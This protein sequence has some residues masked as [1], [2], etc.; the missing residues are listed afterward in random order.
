MNNLYRL[1]GLLLFFFFPVFHLYAGG[2]R[3]ADSPFARMRR[4][5]QLFREKRYDD[6]IAELVLLVDKYPEQIQKAQM[7]VLKIEKIKSQ[8][9]E[10]FLELEEAMLRDKIDVSNNIISEIRALDPYTEITLSN[11]IIASLTIRKEINDRHRNQVFDKA[12]QELAEGQYA[13]SVNTYIDGFYSED[14][15]EFFD[16]YV[17]LARNGQEITRYRDD[18]ERQQRVLSVYRDIAPEGNK[19]IQ[20]LQILVANWILKVG[21]SRRNFPVILQ[22]ISAQPPD[23]WPS[24]LAVPLVELDKT[25]EFL[26]NVLIY[27]EL[28]EE[29]WNQMYERLNQFPEDFRFQRVIQLLK[30]R[31]DNEGKEG[32]IPAIL[33]YWENYSHKIANLMDEIIRSRIVSAMDS[34]NNRLWTDARN[35][36]QIVLAVAQAL[37]DFS[38]S[39]GEAPPGAEKGDS[40]VLAESTNSYIG[41]TVRAW[42][43][44]IDIQSSVSGSIDV[45]SRTLV[46]LD[47]VNQYGDSIQVGLNRAEELL[48][49]WDISLKS[50]SSLYPVTTDTVSFALD[51]LRADILE[52]IRRYREQRSNLYLT[53]MK[54]GYEILRG[55]QTKVFSEEKIREIALLV[56]VEGVT[57]QDTTVPERHPSLAIEQEIT[58]ILSRLG[59][60]EANINTYIDNIDLILD[61]NPPVENSETIGQLREDARKLLQGLS[62]EK[63]RLNDIRVEALEFANRS[64]RFIVTATTILNEVD[65]NLDDARAI[66]ARGKRTN[67]IDD[68][69]DS[70]NLYLVSED[71]LDRVDLSYRNA[72]VNDQ[73]IAT[74]SGIDV[75]RNELR[76]QM[77]ILRNNI[78]VNVRESAIAQA[79]NAYTNNNFSSGLFAVNQAQTFWKSSFNSNDP[80]IE[81]WVIRLRNAIQVLRN[82]VIEPTNPLYSEMTQYINLANQ[83]FLNGVQILQA[84]SRSADAFQAFRSSESLVERV[85][86]VFPGNERALLLEKKILRQTD[87]ESWNAEASRII[88]QSLNA[89]SRNDIQALRGQQTKK[90]LY[91]ELKVLK[92]IDP[93]YPRLDTVLYNVEVALGI[94]IPPTDPAI[95]ARSRQL[96]AEAR[97]VWENLGTKVSDRA[98]SLLNRALSLWLDNNEASVLKSEILLSTKPSLLPALPV[99]VL[100]L[101][102][103]IENSFNEGNY[104]LASALLERVTSRFPRYANDPRVRDL[105]QKV[106]ARL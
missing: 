45:V 93:G 101:I 19:I 83:Y 85:L 10:K 54:D 27:L 38:A 97:Q 41:E 92:D 59:G 87:V 25:R 105:R 4:A 22:D 80:E 72:L 84:N 23:L 2:S 11:V 48:S 65:A 64:R 1:T 51:S 17:E 60:L 16:E 95:I 66:A 63:Q 37:S 67:N 24:I 43:E 34:R 30:G 28:I 20:D 102:I 69:Y 47:I 49:S 96:V 79:R 77:Q 5:E 15:L 73:E 13:Q 106:D 6:S 75:R 68:F 31:P 100:N 32:I 26:G 50:L 21:E 58:P 89:L 98:I 52:I 12:N 82:R 86:S 8:V 74:S 94:V 61:K 35:D 57:G 88:Q 40:L 29:K 9:E 18:P 39:L 46:N 53:A 103:L 76:N 62:N 104:I 99:E 14:Y 44:L 33:A 42:L 90:G 56:N 78:A 36:F 55:Q 91:S 81:A 70:L 71:A 7:L 3:D